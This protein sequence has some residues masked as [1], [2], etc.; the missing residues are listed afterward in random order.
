HFETVAYAPEERKTLLQCLLL[1][2]FEPI[3]LFSLSYELHAAIPTITRDLDEIEPQLGK[4]GLR[5]I[6][7]RGYGVEIEGL[8]S[9]KRELIERLAEQFL[10]E[11]DL[12]GPAPES[13]HAWPVT[14]QLLHLAG[15]E[16]F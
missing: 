6:R 15:K 5:L 14:R 11:S 12:F 2:A 8:E 7:R 10:D 3:K 1:E 13:A 4:Y 16:H 9:C